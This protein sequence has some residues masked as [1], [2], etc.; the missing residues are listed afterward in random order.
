MDGK[1]EPERQIPENWFDNEKMREDKLMA[2]FVDWC[3]ANAIRLDVYTDAE[4]M[5]FIMRFQKAAG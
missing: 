5:E 4:V 3:R 2:G 1:I